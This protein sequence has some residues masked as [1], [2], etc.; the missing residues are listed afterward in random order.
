MHYCAG[1]Q[2]AARLSSKKLCPAVDRRSTTGQG[3]RVWSALSKWDV[4]PKLLPYRSGDLCGKGNR[5]IERGDGWIQGNSVFETQLDWCIYELIETLEAALR[6]AQVQAIGIQAMLRR[7]K[8][9]GP[10]PNRG[11]TCNRCLL[12][13][14]QSIFPPREYHWVHQPHPNK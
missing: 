4:V 6:P 10:T 14:E 9:Q 1:P 2:C 8:T 5:K 11:P 3:Q 12:G 7:K 13:K